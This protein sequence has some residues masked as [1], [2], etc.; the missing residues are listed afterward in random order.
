MSESFVI[1]LNFEQMPSFELS[2]GLKFEQF[3]HLG[4]LST[5]SWYIHTKKGDTILVGSMTLFERSSIKS[6]Q[7]LS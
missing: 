2:D 1:S 6:M 3:M 7:V 5:N 4:M